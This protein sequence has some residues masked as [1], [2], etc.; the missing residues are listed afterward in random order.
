ML[1]TLILASAV[2]GFI[3]ISA[4]DSLLSISIGIKSADIGLKICALTARIKKYRS[5]IKKKKKE[6]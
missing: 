3:S 1:N 4:F 5:I 2:T 6:T